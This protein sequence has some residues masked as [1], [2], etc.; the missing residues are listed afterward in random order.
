[1]AFVFGSQAKD[2]ARRI[3]DWDIGVYFKPKEYLELEVERDYPRRSKIWSDLVDILETDDVDLVVL[4]NARPDMVFSILNSGFPLVIRDKKLYLDL[5]CK[6]H[7]EAVDFWNFVLDF[8]KI[9]EK[10]KSLSIEAKRRIIER[11]V[12]LEEQFKDME[13]FKKLNFTRY[14]D[15]RN[16]RRNVERWVENLVITSLDVA[17][18]ILASEKKEIPQSYQD[19]LKYLGT[20]Y[21]N[22][23]F[24]EKFSKFTELRNIVAHEYLDI[25][26]KQ[27][28][29]FIKEA[30]KLYSKFIK[31]IKKMI[32]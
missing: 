14:R 32:K 23:K 1:M 29:N 6:T 22:E 26:W 9:R 31:K 28:K 12:F 10:T 20:L 13:R 27:I 24:A 3:S 15:D 17:K 30:E 7:Y 11:L 21:F 8:W 25:K 2:L 5:L 16:E 19:T 18:I 4:N